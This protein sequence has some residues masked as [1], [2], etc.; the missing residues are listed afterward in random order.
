MIICVIVNNPVNPQYILVRWTNFVCFSSLFVNLYL[1]NYLI[2]LSLLNFN[3]FDI[4]PDRPSLNSC[5]L[6]LH[7]ELGIPL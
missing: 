3:P 7:W 5:L 4:F 6:E 2:C 1:G